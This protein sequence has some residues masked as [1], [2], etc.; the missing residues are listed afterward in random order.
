[1]PG[2]VPFI[3]RDQQ[4]I[5][6]LQV[7]CCAEAMCDGMENNIRAMFKERKECMALV[8]RGLPASSD[9]N[10]N[11]SGKPKGMLAGSGF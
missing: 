3:K 7:W 6:G 10:S 1:M 9:S 11:N 8:Q 2:I 4:A 5:A